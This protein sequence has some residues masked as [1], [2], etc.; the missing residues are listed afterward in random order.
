MN[1]ELPNEVYEG[2]MRFG[3]LRVVHDVFAYGLTRMKESNPA[4]VIVNLYGSTEFVIRVAKTEPLRG[5]D[6]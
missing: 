2:I 3:R 5:A 1:P 4:W 6:A